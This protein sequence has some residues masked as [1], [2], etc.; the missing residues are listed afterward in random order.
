MGRTAAQQQ[1]ANRYVIENVANLK[2]AA[3]PKKQT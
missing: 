1:V 3:N 2:Y